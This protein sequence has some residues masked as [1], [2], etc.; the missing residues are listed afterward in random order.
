MIKIHVRIKQM[1]GERSVVY[2]RGIRIILAFY[3]QCPAVLHPL[4]CYFAKVFERF[5]SDTR[6]RVF[7]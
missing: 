7:F 5:T 1:G 6:V 4:S 3:L 2:V